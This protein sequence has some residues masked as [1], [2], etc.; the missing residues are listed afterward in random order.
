[1]VEGNLDKIRGFGVAEMADVFQ[2]R[3]SSLCAADTIAGYD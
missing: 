1:V 2:N 3:E